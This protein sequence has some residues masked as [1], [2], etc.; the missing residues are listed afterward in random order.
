MSLTS[1]IANIFSTSPPPHLA[2]ADETPPIGAFGSA[3]YGVA[4]ESRTEGERRKLLEKTMEEEEEARP[5]YLHVRAQ[6]FVLMER[7]ADCRAVNDCWR[8]RWNDR[9]YSDAFN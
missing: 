6:S 3:G 5:P 1:R 2:P 8:Y 9:R 7:I 4:R